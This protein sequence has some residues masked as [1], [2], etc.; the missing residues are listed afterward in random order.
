MGAI[1]KRVVG[2]GGGFAVIN[3]WLASQWGRAG[4]SCMPGVACARVVPW[5]IPLQGAEGIGS[6]SHRHRK[7][8]AE[9]QAGGHAVMRP[10]RHQPKTRHDSVASVGPGRSSERPG[11][12][13]SASP[14]GG[15]VLSSVPRSPSP[16]AVCHA[17]RTAPRGASAASTGVQSLHMSPGH[18][19]VCDALRNPQRVRRPHPP[20]PLA[21]R[22]WSC[23]GS[24]G[25]LT[26]LWR[27][28]PRDSCSPR[29][30]AASGGARD[31]RLAAPNPRFA[32]NSWN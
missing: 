29:S 13:K 11:L 10:P 25:S 16:C 3:L 8:S 28:S 27:N 2:G 17:H 5:A 26:A 6:A 1:R 20:P 15:R 7:E 14:G 18:R 21:F 23:R 22:R 19:V 24:R 4:R 32:S 31:H 9:G 30:P 12:A